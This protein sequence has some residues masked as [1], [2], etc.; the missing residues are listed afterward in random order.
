MSAG[1]LPGDDETPESK[2]EAELMAAK[3][4]ALLARLTASRARIE[5]LS[6]LI[7]WMQAR[8]PFL[9][10]EERRRDPCAPEETIGARVRARIETELA[11]R[12]IDPG[13]LPDAPDA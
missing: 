5:H 12:D 4:A 2:E 1:D 3:E 11:A 7:D 6:G 10:A 9:E 8:W 13:D